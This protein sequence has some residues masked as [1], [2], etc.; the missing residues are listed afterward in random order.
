MRQGVVSYI[1]LSEKKVIDQNDSSSSQ[2]HNKQ[3][4]IEKNRFV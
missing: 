3:L 4:Q 1:D 2:T